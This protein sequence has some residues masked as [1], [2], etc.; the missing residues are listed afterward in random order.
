MVDFVQ[1]DY[2]VRFIK[3]LDELLEKQAIENIKDFC[4]KLDILPQAMSQVR[5][6]KRDVTIDVIIKLYYEFGGNPVYILFGIGGDKI[7]DK[8][9]IPQLPTKSSIQGNKTTEAK[10]IKRLEELVETKNEYIAVLKG[11]VDRLKFQY[12]EKGR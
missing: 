12:G 2:S 4:N 1:R 3:V 5:S 6:G 9:E 10:L 7:L 11:E 8:N